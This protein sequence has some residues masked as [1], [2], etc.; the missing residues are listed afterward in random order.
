MI[1]L[2]RKY[3]SARV[4][5][6]VTKRVLRYQNPTFGAFRTK[7][8]RCFGEMDAFDAGVGACRR[9]TM[10]CLCCATWAPC[11]WTH[12]MT[13]SSLSFQVK[14]FV[15]QKR[16]H[17]RNND[18][19]VSQWLHHEAKKRSTFEPLQ[20]KKAPRNWTQQQSR[21]YIYIYIYADES[22]NGTLFSQKQVK[23]RDAR[24]LNNG[25]RPVSRYKNSGFALF[26]V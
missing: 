15:R 6:V 18:F 1:F 12:W 8:K 16:F 7:L 4:W 3:P 11:F 9:S 20:L 19:W 26:W 22:N 13:N 17:W 14:V 24:T 2:T 10:R 5:G 25:T 21:A 23:Q